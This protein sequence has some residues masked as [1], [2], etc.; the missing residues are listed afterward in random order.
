ML[1]YVHAHTY[2]HTYAHTINTYTQ[3]AHKTCISIVK[4]FVDNTDI[5]DVSLQKFPLS[6]TL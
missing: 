4:I 5:R 1:V 2:M 6:I 3:W